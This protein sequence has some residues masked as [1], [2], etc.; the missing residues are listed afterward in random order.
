MLRAILAIAQVERVEDYAEFERQVIDV[1]G[2]ERK[3]RNAH[4]YA[5]RSQTHST[6]CDWIRAEPDW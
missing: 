1:I 5:W 3:V 4:M 6:H 2:K